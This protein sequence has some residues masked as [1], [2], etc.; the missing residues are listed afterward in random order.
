MVQILCWLDTEDY[1]RMH[2]MHENNQT[3]DYY[4]YRF[5]VE[6]TSSRSSPWPKSAT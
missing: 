6:D 4:A 3:L 2:N 1:W 5:S